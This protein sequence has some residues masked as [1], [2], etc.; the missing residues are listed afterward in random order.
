MDT[1]FCN[2]INIHKRV[3]N[4]VS[5]IKKELYV[6]MNIYFMESNFN[7]GDKITWSIQGKRHIGK[8]INFKEDDLVNIIDE[9]TGNKLT[10]PSYHINLI[11]P[12]HSTI[13]KIE[14]NKIYNEDL[15]N[16]IEDEDIEQLYLY[17]N[18][19]EQEIDDLLFIEGYST[20]FI[21]EDMFNEDDTNETIL[22]KLSQYCLDGENVSYKKIFATY[23][24][25]E[26]S[27]IKPIG[28]NYDDQHFNI[29]ELIDNDICDLI[30]INE[31][32][33]DFNNNNHIPLIDTRL[34]LFENNNIMNNTIYFISLDQ[35]L[36]EK[37]IK[38]ELLANDLDCDDII[39]E[40]KL[41]KNRI[42]NK[43]WP[44]NRNN[45][46]TKVINGDDKEYLDQKNYL[47]EYSNGNKII[48]G[49]FL[50]YI[51]EP[52]IGCDFFELDYFRIIRED[53]RVNMI[54]LYKL[55]SEWRLS[56]ELPFVKWVASTHD[57]IFYKLYK[58]SMIHEGFDTFKGSDSF[59][60]IELCKS[61]I[62]NLYRNNNII[63]LNQY[64]ILHK[65]D[66]II[67]KVCNDEDKREYCSLVIHH[68]GDIEFII[69]KGVHDVV[70]ISRRSTLI[71]LI[72]K[73]NSIIE[74]INQ[75]NV[76]STYKI[77]DFG[78]KS[79]IANIFESS[80]DNE[81]KIDFIDYNIYF[82]TESYEVTEGITKI[83]QKELIKNEDYNPNIR[84]FIKGSKNG[85]YLPLLKNIMKNLP[86]FF[87]YM[88]ENNKDGN[89]VLS[90][91]YKRVNNYANRTTIQSA[92]SSYVSIGDLEV[93]EIINIISREFNKD[94]DDILEEYESW[95]IMM[96]EKREK[97]YLRENNII[98][99]NGPDIIIR[100]KEEYLQFEIKDSKSFKELERVII[101]IKSMMNMLHG[102]INYHDRF[103]NEILCSYLE[104]DKIKMDN[105]DILQDSQLVKKPITFSDLLVSDSDT[106]DTDTDTEEEK[107]LSDDSDEDDDMTGGGGAYEVRSYALKRLKKYDK[108]LFDFQSERYQMNKKT[109]K[110]TSTRYGYAK[111]CQ[112]SKGLGSRQPIA[113]TSD[114]LKRIDNSEDL[115]SGKKS[116][117]KP[118]SVEGRENIN[119]KEVRYICPQ[120]WDV[121]KQL[122]IRQDVA[123]KADEGDI[124]PEELPRDG[125]SDSFI[126]K[127]KGTYWDGIPDV[128]SYKYFVPRILQDRSIHPDGY[129][130]PC[131]FSGVRKEKEKKPPVSSVSRGRQNTIGE[132]NY[133]DL[134]NSNTIICETINTKTKGQLQPGKCSQLPKDLQEMLNQELIFKEDK[135]LDFLKGFIKKGVTQN[136]GE[137]IFNE[138]SFINSYI[139]I[140]D[141]KGDSNS[142]IENEIINVLENNI[143]LFENCSIIHKE[144]KINTISKDDI[145]YVINILKKNKGYK[146]TIIPYLSNIISNDTDISKIQFETNEENY[147]FNLLLS[148]KSYSGYLRSNEEKTHLYIIPILNSIRPLKY[149]INIIIFELIDDVI[150]LQLTDF[151]ETDNMCFIYKDKQYYEPIIYRVNSYS[152]ISHKDEIYIKKE[153][154]IKIDIK[155]FN[156]EYFEEFNYIYT[157]RT[158]IEHILQPYPRGRITE[159][160]SGKSSIDSSINKLCNEIDDLCSEWLHYNEY[161]SIHSIDTNIIGVN[162]RWTEDNVD[163]C[164]YSGIKKYS[165]IK[166]VKDGMVISLEDNEYKPQDLYYKI[167]NKVIDPKLIKDISNKEEWSWIDESC[168]NIRD[169]DIDA[170]IRHKIDPEGDKLLLEYSME[171]K[172][173]KTILKLENDERLH[174]ALKSE[175]CHVLKI[176]SDMNHIINLNNKNTLDEIINGIGSN[177]KLL[178]FYINIYSEVY[179][180]VLNKGEDFILLPI[181]PSMVPQKYETV[182]KIY[183]LEKEY[184]PKF[185]H[186]KKYLK[187]F[188]K[189]IKHLLSIPIDI[190]TV[191][192][193]TIVLQDG[194]YLPIKKKRIKKT[195]NLYNKYVII[196]NTA[197]LKDIDD[198]LYKMN[199]SVDRD[200]MDLFIKKYNHNNKY[201]QLFFN[202]MINAIN[203]MNHEI[204]LNHNDKNIKLNDHIYFI[205]KG[206]NI[207]LLS[208]DEYKLLNYKLIYNIKLDNDY[209]YKQDEIPYFGEIITITE[210]NVTINISFSKKLNI[211]IKDHI[212]RTHDKVDMLINLL[213][214]TGVRIPDNFFIKRDDIF[215]EITNDKFNTMEV[216]DLIEYT[217]RRGKLIRNITNKTKDKYKSIVLISQ[218]LY[219]EDGINIMNRFINK[220]II[221]I[222]NGKPMEDMNKS[223]FEDTIKVSHIEK[224][225]PLEEIFFR[226]SK[227]K[228]KMNERI[229]NLFKKK[230]DFIKTISEKDIEIDKRIITTK[231]NKVPYY[232][233]K[234]YGENSFIAFS[235]NSITNNGSDWFNMT[236]SL[237]AIGIQDINY[238]NE[239]GDIPDIITMIINGLNDIKD[240]KEQKKILNE[241]NKYERIKS[242]VLDIDKPYQYRKYNDIIKRIKSENEHLRIQIPDI[243]MIIKMINKMDI[244][245]GIIF[246]TYNYQKGMDI[247]FEHTENLFND[248]K[249]LSFYHTIY[250]NDYILSNIISD[251]KL[252]NTIPGLKDIDHKH[253]LWLKNKDGIEIKDRPSIQKKKRIDELKIEIDK[254]EEK[255]QSLKDEL[256]EIRLK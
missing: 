166:N 153:N 223:L 186:A 139:E 240:S 144:F 13:M 113:V 67:F 142:F 102:Y 203:T 20:K 146:D 12:I 21:Y 181:E 107:Y 150:K 231:L 44:F 76:Y 205:N 23:K 53:K 255:T 85:F 101:V 189:E 38:E 95:E 234:L 192:I 208:E 207:S 119:G 184:I 7:K 64:E 174:R 148:L 36:T 30:Q 169:K 114:E 170:L 155:I 127:R 238:S 43:Y 65:N 33:T 75:L 232:I 41:F 178:S 35:Y 130:L 122:S 57:N 157:K 116:Y 42:I 11:H 245:V 80:K 154:N 196:E 5:P 9:Q 222:N 143:K 26:E 58:D 161:K 218:E 191:D 121:S 83:E 120:Y 3:I 248:T 242:R 221:T 81:N 104:G 63:N 229:Q 71:M 177:Y 239:K 24:D 37:D 125:R 235:I 111:V 49:D 96:K 50:N 185:S 210:S 182:S 106:D 118:L 197:E 112:A 212:I 19:K 216:N 138:S 175:F 220:L 180:I 226:Y 91:H 219:N 249:I 124:I 133:P 247:Y 214:N 73:C 16:D 123:L 246:I 251:D 241:Y 60:D 52:R 10:I 51:N 62:G 206:S 152:W 163:G 141:Y 252:I 200:E 29:D 228:D 202:Y 47:E 129:G 55:F 217:D 27:I 171:K 187:D 188:K 172:N 194:T 128:D 8:I 193:V 59:I 31:R 253:N 224:S 84:P 151:I 176:M 190:D 211:I 66:V 236:E 14:E 105:I 199:H 233:K 61:W 213:C 108:D 103:N 72:E 48:Y 69:K 149:A 78:D 230:S 2:N 243:K 136:N 46:L 40:I 126:L 140:I 93:E 250:N 82:R 68:N 88:I 227:N 18:C 164:D 25:N 198:S 110:K 79:E 28:F 100:E 4:C 254:E 168:H 201:L 1:N 34:E 183:N 32:F 225:T 195:D 134:Y 56:T 87:R 74:Q 17:L 160:R 137:Y 244:D 145:T 135:D 159:L 89:G 22:I 173:Q 39:N 6:F 99:E 237:K 204:T 94:P 15:F 179:Y 117:Y 158:F 156:K 70:S 92:I 86:M 109:G 77:I 45:T 54:N 98:E 165:K 147:K 97:G 209:K 90:G 215:K 162:I 256:E 115:G 167:E 132:I 131:C